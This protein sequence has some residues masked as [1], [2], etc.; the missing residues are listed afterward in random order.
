MCPDLVQ[1]ST[2]NP[3]ATPPGAPGVWRECWGW[4]TAGT[5]RGKEVHF[6]DVCVQF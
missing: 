5:E 4:V 1:R 3:W 2:L 6:L